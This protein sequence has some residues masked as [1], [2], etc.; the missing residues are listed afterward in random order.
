MRFILDAM[1][2][3]ILGASV[4]AILGAGIFLGFW[5]WRIRTVAERIFPEDTI[6]Y[7]SISDIRQAERNWNESHLGKA[8]AESPRRDVYRRLGERLSQSVESLIGAD[9]RPLTEQMTRDA[10]V[11]VFPLPSGRRGLGVVAYAADPEDVK[12]FIE[13]KL[14]PGWRRR[15][16]SLKKGIATYDRISYYKYSSTRFPASF[17]PCYAMIEHHLLFA[18]NEES[19]KRILDTKEKKNRSL[20]SSA[21]FGDAR[22]QIDYKRGV[23]FYFNPQSARQSLERNLPAR[24]QLIWPEIVKST[25]LGGLQYVAFVLRIEDGDFTTRGF[26]GVA[27]QPTG[28]LKVLMERAPRKFESVS[29][30]PENAQFFYSATMPDF[31]RL[32]QEAGANWTRLWLFVQAF[33]GIDFQHELLETLGEEITFFSVSPEVEQAPSA[34]LEQG[35]T[36]V[37]PKSAAV[38][39][40]KDSQRFEKTLNKLA[41]L[42]ESRGLEHSQQ[43]YQGSTITQ[44]RLRYGSLGLAPSYALQTPWFF[45]ASEDALLKTAMDTRRGGKNLV[46]TAECRAAMTG[47]PSDTNALSCTRVP[48]LLKSYAILLRTEAGA[49]PWIREY[50]L[51]EEMAYLASRL[52]GAASYA[53]VE[54]N[55]IAY[56]SRSSVPSGFL[57]LPP[58]TARLPELLSLYS[59]NRNE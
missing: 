3:V 6:V 43:N 5:F 40:L 32:N 36:T 10:A 56:G 14:D 13:Q 16:P 17:Q 52:S 30:V 53:R 50:G 38:M 25:G 27:A 29:A 35:S 26:A 54:K 34:E 1:K 33:T 55:G 12:A 44:F 11:A 19:M 45:V 21:N 49:N 20:R 8:I 37:R 39:L 2:K 59:K 57:A 58:L 48:E 9:P 51:D 7:V 22:K 47:F 28:L 42:A 31:S 18:A 41:S 24:A 46:S 23:L 15:D 4:V